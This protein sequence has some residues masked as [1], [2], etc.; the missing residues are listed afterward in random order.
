M[1]DQLYNNYSILFVDDEEKTRKYFA[2]LFGEKFDVL[3]AEDGVDHRTYQGS[4]VLA[5]APLGT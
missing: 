1:S 3:L 5:L 2:R 4:Q